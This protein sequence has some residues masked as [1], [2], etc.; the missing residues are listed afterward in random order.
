MADDDGVIKDGLLTSNEAEFLLKL[1]PHT[2]RQWR[3]LGRGP[4]YIKDG[5]IVRYAVAD[6]E[7][8]V[9]EH[10]RDGGN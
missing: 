2:L 9:A 8:W 10:R 3:V 1:K 5:R 7:R 4:E 6:L